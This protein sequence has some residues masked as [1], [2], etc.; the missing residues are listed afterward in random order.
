[1]EFVSQFL[2]N[3]VSILWNLTSLWV[4]AVLTLICKGGH[5]LYLCVWW[6][7]SSVLICE[8]GYKVN[9]NKE[10]KSIIKCAMKRRSIVFLVEWIWSYG[11]CWN[12]IENIFIFAILNSM[13]YL[14]KCLD[15]LVTMF[16][17]SF[18]F[19]SACM[20]LSKDT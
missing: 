7:Q 10:D 4:Q 3:H 1:M 16:Q 18:P 9:Q 12:W 19:P 17:L 11:L 15:K 6:V 2:F 14:S 13:I 8:V 5:K 20:L